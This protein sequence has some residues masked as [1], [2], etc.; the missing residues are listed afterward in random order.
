[1]Q[2]QNV[3]P[4]NNVRS[5]RSYGGTA[6]VNY[7]A[8]LTRDLSFSLNQM[9]FITRINNALSL[10][11][12]ISGNYFFRNESKPVVSKGF[13]TNAKLIFKK[14]LKL[15]AG[16][17]FTD[18]KAKYFSGNQYLT[19]IAKNKL[20]LALVYEKEKDFKIGLEGYYTDKQYLGNGSSTPFFWEFGAA[21]EKTFKKITL[22]VNAE[23]F[24]D[25][26]QSSYK[27]VANPP[28]NAPS[29]DEIWTHTEGFV[30]NGGIKLKL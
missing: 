13:E 28:H 3:L 2:F 21:A 14:H 20:N 11:N 18:A 27:S 25:T 7:T 22:F 30:F 10:T 4:L 5:E 23:N 8:A 15:F 12:D 17:T 6:D 1:M 16:Y 26:R 19:L 24:T 9:F 29:F